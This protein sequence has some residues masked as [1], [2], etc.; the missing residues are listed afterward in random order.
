V[1]GNHGLYD[2]LIVKLSNTGTIEWQKS[3]GG[4]STDIA[5]DIKETSDQGYIVVGESTSNNGDATGNHG[6]YDFWV[7][8]L[9]NGTGMNEQEPVSGFQAYPNPCTDEFTIIGDHSLIDKYLQITNELGIICFEGTIDAV[10]YNLNVG[11]LAKGIYFLHIEG[12]QETIK[13]IKE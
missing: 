5:Y 2:Y 8:K 12:D 7:V 10:K 6:T 4:T 9:G 3:L 13:L 1:T 11:H